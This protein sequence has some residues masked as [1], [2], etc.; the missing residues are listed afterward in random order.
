MTFGKIKC[1]CGK[2]YI[3]TNER[4]RMFYC[5]FCYKSSIDWEEHYIRAYGKYKIIDIFEPPW[6]DIEEEYH[7]A[8]IGWLNDSDEEYELH[9][10]NNVLYVV[11][12]T[13]ELK[14]E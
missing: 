14:N 4:H 11:K 2:I 13:E 7:S 8:F 5:P 9:K 10:P 1:S 12:I 6:F 3:V